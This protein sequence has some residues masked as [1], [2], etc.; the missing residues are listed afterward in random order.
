MKKLFIMVMMAAIATTSFAQGFKQ[1]KSIKDY[2]QAKAFMEANEASMEDAEKGKCYDYILNKLLADNATKA[3]ATIAATNGQNIDGADDIM[4]YITTA[5]KT[6]AVQG[7]KNKAK[8]CESASQMRVVCLWAAQKYLNNDN[9]KALGYINTYIESAYDPLFVDVCGDKDQ[10]VFQFARIAGLINYQQENYPDAKK[11]AEM[12]MKGPEDKAD[13]EPIYLAAIEKM[14]KTHQDTLDYISTMQKLDQT[15]HFA[16]IV[17]M[18]SRI[19]ELEKANKLVE[20]EIAANPSNKMAYALKG[21]NAMNNRDWNAAI[22]AFK[23]TVEIDPQY[24]EVWFNLGVCAYSKASDLNEKYSDK[25]GR[26]AVDK[27]KEVNEVIA[28][29]KTYYEKVRELDPNYEKIPNWPRQLRMVYNA[30]GEKDKAAEIS[31]MLGDE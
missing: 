8:L 13:A 5:M 24:T 28:E 1:L 29:A 19:G 7:G 2:A 6:N 16:R 31:K 14:A 17:A 25:Q 30:L 9:K 23:K 3:F 22:D 11:Y 12:A 4:N 15:K 10:N 18:Y 27:A 20:D 26:I 21:E